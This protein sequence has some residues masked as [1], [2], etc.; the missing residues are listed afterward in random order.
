MSSYAQCRQ[1]KQDKHDRKR[2][3]GH[4]KWNGYSYLAYPA[5]CDHAYLVFLTTLGDDPG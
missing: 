1:K 3:D 2:Q 4:D 5:T